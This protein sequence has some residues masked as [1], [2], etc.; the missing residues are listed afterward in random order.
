MKKGLVSIMIPVYNGMPDIQ[1]SIKSLLLQTYTNWECIIINDGSTD[2]TREYIDSLTDSRFVVFHFFENKGR[3]YARQKGLDLASGE[4]MAMLDADDFY[5]PR[6]LE[7]QVNIMTHNPDIYLVGTGICSFGKN[8]NFIRIRQKGNNTVKLYFDNNG[9]FPATNASM[10]RT[11]HAKKY[12]YDFSLKLGQDLDF[13]KRYLIGKRFMVV[14]DILYYYSE[15]DSVNL[16]KIKHTHY[17][18]LIKAIKEKKYNQIIKLGIKVIVSNLIFPILGINLI[19]RKRGIKPTENELK[20][21]N[22][23]LSLIN[24]IN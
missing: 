7:M 20:E 14:P 13:L 10:I 1:L 22:K 12:K 23:T 11:G 9:L 17:Y 2:G 4:Y 5:H 19:L 6:K 8:I 18:G 3:P 16:T 15:F 21:F 24:N